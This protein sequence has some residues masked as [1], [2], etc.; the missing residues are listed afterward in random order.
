MTVTKILE[1]YDYKM[2]EE[3][4]IR[5]P[6]IRRNTL[7]RK[8]DEIKGNEVISLPLKAPPRARKQ[9]ANIDLHPSSSKIFNDIRE[10]Q[11]MMIGMHRKTKSKI[12]KL[13][14]KLEK[15]TL[16]S[17]MVYSEEDDEDIN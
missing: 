1:Y 6:K 3:T 16:I 15:E 7:S 10:D 5:H 11:L 8:R 14:R 12:C 2:E 17:P 9:A 4:K 13:I